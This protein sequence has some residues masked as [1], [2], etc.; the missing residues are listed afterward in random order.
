MLEPAPVGPELVELGPGLALH[1]QVLKL[2]VSQF[3]P[4]GQPSMN[5]ARRNLAFVAST[6]LAG[7]LTLA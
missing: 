4:L 7:N 2:L 6:G 5:V 3:E 1:V